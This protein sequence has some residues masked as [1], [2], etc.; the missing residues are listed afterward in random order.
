MSLEL[1]SRTARD[2]HIIPLSREVDRV[3]LPFAARQGRPPA[4]H[5]HRFIL[6]VPETETGRRI[7]SRVEQSLAAIA[8][9]ERLPLASDR[10]RPTAGFQGLLQQVAAL[11]RRELEAGNRVHINLSSGSKLAAFAAGIAGMAHIRPGCGSVYYVQPHGTALS[12]QEFDEHGSTVGV[13]DV[14]DLELMPILLPETMHLRVLE[15]LQRQ[16]SQRIE[17]RDLLRFLCDIPGSGYSLPLEGTALKVRNWN[18]AVTTRMVRKLV[19]PLAR[20]GLIEVLD[21]GRQRA[22]QLTARGAH[23]AALGGFEALRPKATVPVQMVELR[24]RP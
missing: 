13:L 11:C 18:N 3:V 19:T 22:V 23:Y 7:A 1:T 9:V 14:E 12:E 17:Y 6:L 8:P 20:Q 10:D 24:E 4:L 16:P 2:V 5:A 15:L 21:G